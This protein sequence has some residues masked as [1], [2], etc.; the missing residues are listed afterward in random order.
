MSLSTDP[1]F[2]LLRNDFVCGFKDISNKHY[3]GA[4][5][6]HEP[7]GNAVET[8]NGAGPHNLQ[9]FILSPDGTV[10]HCLPGYWCSQDLANEL[11]FAQELNKVWV[12]PG[13]SRDQKNKLFRQMQ[14]AHAHEHSQAER[15]RSH[16]QGFD[17]QYEAQHRL[18]NTDVFYDPQA[19]DPTGKKITPRAVKTAD[20]IFHE[21][22]ANRPFEH[23]DKFDVAVFSDYGKPM[24]DKHE[25]F[26]QADGQ[27]APGADLS[28][29]PL[30]GNDPRAHPVK[31]EIK[32][33]GKSAAR[34]AVSSFIKYGIRSALAH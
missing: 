18:Y 28:S 19:V 23:Y 6:K 15:G 9:M 34:Q 33:Q 27:I 31:T 26:R 14:L 32:R 16:L 8:T 21:R 22:M 11:R 13:L 1:T 25:D 4:S 12:D 10:L 20:L 17:V 24:Y 7:D 29:E 3:A 2:A 30:I 5:G